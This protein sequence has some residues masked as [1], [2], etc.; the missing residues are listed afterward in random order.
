MVPALWPAAVEAAYYLLA[1]MPPAQLHG[2]VAHLSR[3]QPQIHKA[4]AM[5]ERGQRQSVFLLR[6]AVPAAVEIWQ[7]VVQEQSA[8]SHIGAAQVVAVVEV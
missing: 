4:P 8:I 3:H 5:E 7:A 1:R 6:G 2:A